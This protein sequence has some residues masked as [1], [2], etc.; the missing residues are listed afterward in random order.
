MAVPFPYPIMLLKAEPHAGHG[1]AVSLQ[2]LLSWE[3]S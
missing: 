3:K 1:S 2:K